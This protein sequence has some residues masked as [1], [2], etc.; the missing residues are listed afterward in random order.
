MASASLLLTLVRLSVTDEVR[1]RVMSMY[2]LA[3]AAGCQWEVWC[4]DRLMPLYGV[5]FSM[6]STG[7]IL[8]LCPCISCSFSGA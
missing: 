6:A 8:V 3:S 2:N 5:S 4:S 7:S 1:G